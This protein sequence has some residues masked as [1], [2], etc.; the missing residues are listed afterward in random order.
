MIIN[1]IQINIPV[2]AG[3]PDL[4]LF[5]LTGA[6]PEISIPQGSGPERTNCILVIVTIHNYLVDYTTYYNCC[7]ML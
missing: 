6:S 2:S 7:N 4:T 3:E 5:T 1:L